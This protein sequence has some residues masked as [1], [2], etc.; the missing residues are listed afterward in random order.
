M[1]T[2][3]D[4]GSGGDAKPI[5]KNDGKP[6][7]RNNARRDNY[8][9]KKE[10]FMGADPNLRGHVF[11]AKNS[12]SDQVANY[13]AVDDM[14]KSQAGTD[15]D[16][17]VLESLENERVMMPTEPTSPPATTV[18]KVTINEDKS[19]STMQV[20]TY[21]EI[22]RMKWKAKYDK[23]LG[24]VEKV[25][26]QLTQVYSKYYGQCDDEMKSS[27]KEDPDFKQAHI[28][29]DVIKLRK[30]LKNV[31]FS[32]KKDKEPFK[33]LWQANKDFM[34]MKQH[35]SSVTEYY[36]KYKTLQKVVTELSGENIDDAYVD[37]IC[38]EEEKVEANLSTTERAKMVED[39]R[40]RMMAM[41]FIMN[42]DQD[43]YGSL[44]KGFDRDYLSKINKYPKTVHDAHNLLKGWHEKV[45]RQKNGGRLGL[46]FNTMGDDEGSKKVKCPRCGRFNHTREQCVARTHLDG[47]VLHVDGKAECAEVLHTMGEEVHVD[48]EVSTNNE[49][50]IDNYLHCGDEHEEL[51][52]LQPDVDRMIMRTKW[53]TSSKTRSGIPV[54]WMLL[55]SQSTIDVFSNAELLTEIHE[56]DTTL[57]IRCNAG[58]KTT[59]L[60]GHLSG[61]GWVWYYPEGIAN[62][63]SLSRVKERYRVTFDSA[64][65]NSFHVHKD[66]GKILK[67]REACRR[68]Y[69]FDTDEREEEAHM[70][71]TTVD[72]NKNKL[73]AFDFSQ[74][75]RARALQRR[76]GRPNTKDFIQYVSQNLIPNCPITVKD[77]HNAEFVW[78]PDI[79]SLKGKTVRKQSPQVRVPVYD[80]PWPIMKQYKDVTLSVDV[81][82]VSGI[83]FLMTISKHIKFGSAGK[84]DNMQNG[85][86]M[87]HFKAIIGAYT[88][89]GFR[90]TIIMADNQ[91]ESMRGSLADLHAQLHITSRDEHVPDIERYNRTIK[92]RVRANHSMLPFTHVPPIIVIEMVYT[93]V[94]WR[95][96]FPL[97]GGV[98]NTQSPA[99]LVLNRRINFNTH[100]KVEFGEYVQTHEEHDNTMQ[101]RT[102]GAI[103]TRPSND[104][105]S[106]HFVS[107]STGRVINRRNWTSVPMPADVVDQVHRLARR[108]KSRKTL[109]FTNARNVDLDILY[110][111]IPRDDDDIDLTG[112]IAGVDDDEQSDDDDEEYIPGNDSDSDSESSNSDNEEDDDET[113][114]SE[115]DD[116]GEDDETPGVAA[117]EEDDEIPG[118]AAEIPG[119][120]INALPDAGETP[121]VAAEVPG[122]AINVLP[123]AGETQGEVFN[124]LPNT[125]DDATNDERAN[126]RYDLRRQPRVEYRHMFNV[127]GDEEVMMLNFNPGS[128]DL[129][130]TTLDEID[131]EYI[132]LTEEMGWKEGL[133]NDEP[134]E[135]DTKNV[136]KLAEYLFLTDQMGWRKGLKVLGPEK[137]EPAITKEL[138]QIHDMEGFQ[139]KHWYEMTKEERAQALRYL[140]YLKEKRDGK[141]KG[142]GC[143]DGRP[144]RLYT[145]KSETSSPTA[146]LAA[147]MLTCMIEAFEKRDVATVDIP[148]AFLQTKQPK[149]EKDVHVVLDGRMAELLAK[150]SPETYQEYV[151]QKRG[152]SLIYCKLN[153]ALYGTL[154]A[155]L[156]F[157]KKLSTSLKMRGF[158]INPYDWCVANKDINGKQCTIVWHV[159]DLKI[160]HMDPKVIDG[161]ISSLNEEY[162][163]VGEMTVRRG[164]V[165]EYL[166]MTLDFTHEGK[167]IVDMEAY[168]DEMIKDLPGDMGGKAT[169]PAADHLFRTRDDAVKLDEERAEL[170]HKVTAQ[171]LFVAQ[172]GR[173]DLRTAVSFLT[174]RV[175]SPDEDDYKKLARAI[176]YIRRTKFLRLTIEATYLDQNHWFIDGAFAVHDNM[177]SHTGAYMTFGKGMVDGSCTG[178][179]INTTSSTEAEV[180]AIHDNMGAILWARYF[181]DAQGYPL[182]PSEIHQDNLSSM[183]L[184]TNGRGSSGKRTRHM[185][186]RYFFVADV[187][188]RNHVNI[189]HCPTDE[190]IG[191]FFTKPL[192]GSKFRR[193]RNIIMNIDHDEYGAVDVDELTSIHNAKMAK[194]IEMEAHHAEFSKDDHTLGRKISN[195]ACSQEC[196]GDVRFGGDSEGQNKWGAPRRSYADVVAE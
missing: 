130:E 43:L 57:R 186:I 99:E 181:L 173:P 141:I 46:S 121:G 17:L 116:A 2:N 86:I 80:I 50:F 92:E 178:Q 190:M 94:F 100:C 76:I 148:G 135:Y 138:Q 136:T 122:V 131:E 161:I 107:L 176:K 33:T 144:Q 36:E 5:V 177:R 63:L 93:A 113:E 25:E 104:A 139:P 20:T 128:D 153:V 56:S 55:D 142:R 193:F 14:I 26:R 90:V 54:S 168:L 184:E 16:P 108:A 171:M 18:D 89:R 29:K 117:E 98:S 105:G 81:M 91:F 110:A 174:K 27:M 129:E 12:R 159:D 96:M 15:Y 85:H 75:K 152:Q 37:I 31:N 175:Q 97:K 123:D 60:K 146:A 164:K 101:P 150:I 11:E 169:T 187:Q 125:G 114:E 38:R 106:Y 185:N 4:A 65:D 155:A 158:T 151:H 166:G 154:K 95:N 70:L 88:T 180:V 133:V 51:M 103:A 24:R 9:V 32:Y 179:K 83:P 71:I 127:N 53:T 48:D 30:I 47:T 134:R 41:Q 119:V 19:T 192:G 124:A 72:D 140:M 109:T 44:I 68:L 191:D 23:Y 132:F 160:S 34:N 143:A 39:G 157:W 111:D 66:D 13:K 162:G 84:L 64:M 59:K 79:G 21:D 77:I 196:V 7:A 118:V 10:R 149:E 69:Y 188:R 163:K 145:D 126:E 182:K 22:E 172:R 35:K 156:L 67:F 120:A 189:V 194:R 74:A 49:L 73:S 102:I 40:E 6:P 58:M 165:H 62:I 45:T 195:N 61:Y 170:F 3:T 112:E 147:I 167:F 52:F 87:K 78:G 1:S 137:G 8:Y 115:D 82:K 42:S 28:D 183:L